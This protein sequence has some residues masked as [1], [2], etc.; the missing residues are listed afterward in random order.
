MRKVSSVWLCVF[1]IG[2]WGASA[3]RG[4]SGAAAGEQF[5]GKWTATWEGSGSGGF[6]LTLEKGAETALGGTVAVTGEPAYQATL[7]TV[8]FD[9]GKMSAKYDF[10]PAAQEAEVVLAGTFEGS[11]ATGTWTLREKASGNEVASG[12]WTVAKKQ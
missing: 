4:T 11:K 7:K 9:G 10:T 3:Q 12:T 8:T 6:E 2:A 5:A 1:V